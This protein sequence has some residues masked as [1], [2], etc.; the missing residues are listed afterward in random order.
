MSI[1][2]QTGEKLPDYDDG[3]ADGVDIDAIHRWLIEHREWG[4]GAFGRE[5][6]AIRSVLAALQAAGD[7]TLIKNGTYRMMRQDGARIER[8][9]AWLSN[10]GHGESVIEHAGNPVEAAINA[11]KDAD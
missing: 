8:L 2:P 7:A 4:T 9:A 1:I 6:T 11:L 3:P 10:H 5:I